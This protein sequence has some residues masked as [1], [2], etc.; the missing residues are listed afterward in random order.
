MF[1]IEGIHKGSIPDR[2]GHGWDEVLK[3][4]IT[5]DQELGGMIAFDPCGL[6]SLRTQDLKVEL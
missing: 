3:A 1:F 6:V 5:L 2:T 4:P